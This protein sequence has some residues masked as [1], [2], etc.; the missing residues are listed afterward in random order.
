MRKKLML[1]LT[2]AAAASLIVFGSTQP[3]AHRNVVETHADAAD[4]SDLPARDEMHQRFELTPG[5]QV[6]LSFINGRVD[7]E[8]TD[9]NTAEVDITRSARNRDDLKFDRISI[10]H[11]PDSLVL[12]G[13]DSRS[14]Q[15]EVRQRVKLLI[16]RQSNFNV[17]EVNGTVNIDRI[18][19]SVG[20]RSVNGHLIFS[21]GR[22]ASDITS[23][24]GHMTISI[25][26]LADGGIR[27][28]DAVSPVLL[29]VADDINADL[30]IKELNGRV[31]VKR[32][33]V[34]VNRVS[35]TNYSG[36]IGS[37]GPSI[38]IIDVRGSL[39]IAS[40]DSRN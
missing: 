22:G 2:T 25:D 39:T 20:V 34:T 40:G 12:R 5:A 16:P 17:R 13:A 26:Q 18:D 29:Q 33:N 28:S 11:T 7:V 19:G 27:I 1:L 32:P 31:S 24:N 30:N 35:E 3:G 23:V 21:Q 15:V 36:Q 4:E 14:G 9:G 38:S 8:A 10:E 37:G 6:Q